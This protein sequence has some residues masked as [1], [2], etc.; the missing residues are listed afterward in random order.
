MALV[1]AQAPDRL[2][3]FLALGDD[4]V[5]LAAVALAAHQAGEVRIPGRLLRALQS[6]LVESLP[7]DA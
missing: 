1:N 7:Q 5:V 2:E 3:E 6:G 4:P